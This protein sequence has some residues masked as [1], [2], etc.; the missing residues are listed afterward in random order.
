[1]WE[2]SL[3]LDVFVDIRSFWN[4]CHVTAHH[5]Y[6]RLVIV[7]CSPLPESGYVLHIDA[8]LVQ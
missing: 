5:S 1:M 4:I 8:S 6:I 2:L 7:S 3:Y